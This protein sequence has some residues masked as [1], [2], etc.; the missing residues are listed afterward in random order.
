[1]ISIWTDGACSGNP[2]RG[3]YAAYIQLNNSIHAICGH[4][5]YT[6]NNRMELSGF[7][8]GITAARDIDVTEPVTVY[9]DSKYIENA[10]NCGWLKKWV[11][12]LYKGVKNSDLWVQIEPL[13]NSLDINVVWVKGHSSTVGNNM[14]DKLACEARD[15]IHGKYS[16]IYF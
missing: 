9:T 1:M 3:G 4:E 14:A 15:G 8:V 6:T 12:K 2:G 16:V 7:L 11:K 13:M 10:I 5:A